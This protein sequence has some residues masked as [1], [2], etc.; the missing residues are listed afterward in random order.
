MRRGTD[1]TFF[2]Q[3]VDMLLWALFLTMPWPPSFLGLQSSIVGK[4]LLS[5]FR[6]NHLLLMSDQNP[7]TL[8]LTPKHSVFSKNAGKSVQQESPTFDG[9]FPIF[10][11]FSIHWPLSLLLLGYKSALLLAVFRAEPYLFSLSPVLTT[12]CNSL[13]CCFNRCLNNFPG[14]STSGSHPETPNM[15][16]RS[17]SAT[18]RTTCCV[19][20]GTGDWKQVSVPG[21]SRYL[22]QGWGESK[23]SSFLWSE[24]KL[25]TSLA[26]TLGRQLC[27]A[28]WTSHKGHRQHRQ[29]KGIWTENKIEQLFWSTWENSLRN[30]QKEQREDLKGLHFSKR[31]ATI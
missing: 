1:E 19:R 26:D 20:P 25:E 13:L 29:K 9:N 10:L 11:W 12:Y 7:Q 24:G 6:E 2:D 23:N 8:L 15:D 14:N 18:R 28:E 17:L 21:S 3:T 16:T 5:Q 27:P 4:I 31:I 30:L 22:H